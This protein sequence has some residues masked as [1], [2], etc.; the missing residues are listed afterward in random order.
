MR[1]RFLLKILFPSLFTINYSLYSC[2]QQKFTISGYVKDTTTGENLIGATVAVKGTTIGT[3][4]NDYGF[5]SLT[6]AQGA[7]TITCSYLG[8]VAKDTALILA[9]DLRLN[10]NL[11]TEAQTLSEVVVSA[12]DTKDENVKSAEMGKFELP[13]ERIK[14]L[15]VIF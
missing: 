14:N 8:Y 10:I 9:R 4:A 13:M 1:L 5:Y 2:A 11:K 7:Y 3:A 6:L 12:N 15:P